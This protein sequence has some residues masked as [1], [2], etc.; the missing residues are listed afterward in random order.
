MEVPKAKSRPSTPLWDDS[1]GG[2]VFPWVWCK[3]SQE[4]RRWV[5]VTLPEKSISHGKIITKKM[6]SE[7]WT[8][9]IS[10]KMTRNPWTGTPVEIIIFDLAPGHEGIPDTFIVCPGV[11]YS[12]GLKGLFKVLDIEQ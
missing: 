12:I 11:H 6:M 9:G 4:G 10:T 1:R 5:E 2:L 7:S 8:E 3:A